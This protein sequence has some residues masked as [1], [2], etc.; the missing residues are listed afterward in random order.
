[1]VERFRRRYIIQTVTAEFPAATVAYFLNKNLVIRI[2]CISGCP[3][4]AVGGFDKVKK[5]KT[6]PGYQEFENSRIKKE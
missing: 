5:K 4:F 6:I 3:A 1:V 2:F